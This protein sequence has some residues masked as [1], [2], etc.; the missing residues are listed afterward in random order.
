MIRSDVRDGVT[1]R[2][3]S[4]ANLTIDSNDLTTG[5][6]AN[7]TLARSNS[8]LN[9]FFSR[10]AVNEIVLNWGRGNIIAGINDSI[11][12]N[13]T[14]NTGPVTTSYTVSINQGFYNVNTLLDLIVTRLNAQFA[15]AV[16]AITL[17]NGVYAMTVSAG[18][19]FDFDA[20]I[21]VQQLGIGT[22][23]TPSPLHAITN[24]VV[25]PYTYLDFVCNDLTYNQSLKDATTNPIVR[26]VLYRWYFAWDNVPT[27]LDAYGFP[28]LQGYSPFVC[29]RALPFPK[30]IRWENNMPVGNLNF[31]V[32]GYCPQAQGGVYDTP[33]PADVAAK[34]YWAMSL[35]VSED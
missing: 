24:P 19:I 20:G 13:L 26:D 29:R 27:A 30:Q 9:G 33:L 15:P 10:L 25:L 3:P 8:I 1:I 6:A 11:R 17:G 18:Y 4:T 5:N 34:M 7:F 23:N 22:P 28:I 2:N 12:V 14:N 35:L 16:F 32:Y 21:L 31:Q